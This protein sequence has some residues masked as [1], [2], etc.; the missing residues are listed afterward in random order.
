[1]SIGGLFQ[2]PVVWALSSED[3]GAY[4]EGQFRPI[5]LTENISAVYAEQSTMGLGQPVIQFIR[6]NADT[7][8]FQAKVWAYSQGVFGTG[9]GKN[10]LA[11]DDIE[12]IVA[13][14]KEL[15]R[16]TPD[17]GR[18]EVYILTVGATFSQRVVV[19]SVGGI[20]YD[21]MRPSQGVRPRPHQI[22]ADWRVNRDTC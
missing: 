1:M 13:V 11:Q 18:P 7:I 10:A 16:P 4:I 14:I 22:R 15:P 2:K 21:N 3:T 9:L 12:D 6:G 8:K 5:G 20:R 19:R 17:L